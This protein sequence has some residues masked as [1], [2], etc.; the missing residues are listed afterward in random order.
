MAKRL[1]N[2]NRK[3][4]MDLARAYKEGTKPAKHK[5]AVER[6]KKALKKKAYPMT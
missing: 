2:K 3:R 1:S 5:V 6:S 4:R